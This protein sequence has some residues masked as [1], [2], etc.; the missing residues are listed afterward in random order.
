MTG[1]TRWLQDGSRW[2]ERPRPDDGL[3][4]KRSEGL[5]IELIT[6]GLVNHACIM[7]PHK[8]PQGSEGFPPGC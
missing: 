1:D 4:W 3:G 8:N 2:P 5:E 6:S 7:E